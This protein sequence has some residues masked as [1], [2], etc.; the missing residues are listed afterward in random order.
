MTDQ[1]LHEFAQRLLPVY[2]RECPECNGAGRV[3]CCAN[4][5]AGEPSMRICRCR[6]IGLL[7][8]NHEWWESHGFEV[9]PGYGR[10]IG[11]D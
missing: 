9:K 11:C 8:S 1:E 10:G 3:P 6:G 4:H 7:I 5:R 2:K